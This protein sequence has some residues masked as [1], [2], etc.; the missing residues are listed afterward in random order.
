MTSAE[1]L[2]SQSRIALLTE[3]IVLHIIDR[4]DAL[5]KITHD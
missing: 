5:K 4:S 1:S 2:F 3:I